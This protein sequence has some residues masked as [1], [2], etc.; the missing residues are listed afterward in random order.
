MDMIHGEMRLPSNYVTNDRVY[1]LKQTV[2]TITILLIKTQWT[3][4]II[5]YRDVDE[6]QR[7]KSV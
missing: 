1:C 2:V 3:I 6:N 5:F 7:N 4:F